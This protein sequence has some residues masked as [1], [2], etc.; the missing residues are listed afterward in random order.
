MAEDMCR[1]SEVTVIT[2]PGIGAVV[3]AELP[4]S[5]AEGIVYV[6]EG[7]PITTYTWD[8]TQFVPI[9]GGGGDCDCDFRLS[10]DFWLIPETEE[11]VPYAVVRSP[12]TLI[13]ESADICILSFFSEV[14][15][16]GGGIASTVYINGQWYDGNSWSLVQ[17]G[18]HGG[19]SVD[20][21]SVHP[22]YQVPYMVIDCDDPAYAV[23]ETID[24]TITGTVD[25]VSATQ[26]LPYTI[27]DANI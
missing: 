25:G 10:P 19:L 4:A 11:F 5:G 21:F 22:D 1:D 16:G 15:S 6:I 13:G 3:L 24:L 9:G 23:G 2:P 27:V 20:G 12:G 18:G 17:Q 8:G 14:I 7:D 26:T